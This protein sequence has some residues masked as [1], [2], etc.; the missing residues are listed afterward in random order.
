MAPPN[1]DFQ[2]TVLNIFQKAPFVQH[3][4]IR[5]FEVERGRCS[6]GLELSDIH[7]QQ[8]GF[9]HAGVLATLA[10][11][12]AGG[13]GATLVAKDEAV[14]SVEFKINLLRPAVGKTLRCTAQ[15]LKAGKRLTVVESE[16][17]VAVDETEKLVAKAVVTLA[18]VQKI[19]AEGEKK[20]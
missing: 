15:V 7:L 10:D 2:K 18:I 20:E 4:G 16:V 17:F 3:L 8:D 6:T 9:V 13:A 12:T 5:L 1:P 14:L 11:H 19:P